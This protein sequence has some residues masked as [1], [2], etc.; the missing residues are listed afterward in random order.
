MSNQCFAPKQKHIFESTAMSG[1]AVKCL[2]ACHGKW[3]IEGAT[4]K[5]F[6]GAGGRS[7]GGGTVG[8]M[9]SLATRQTPR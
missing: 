3:Y 9:V 2:L 1:N 8:G 5:L 7:G 6:G 4:C